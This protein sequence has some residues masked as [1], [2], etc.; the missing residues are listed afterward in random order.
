MWVTQ[1]QWVF[2]YLIC[3]LRWR[4]NRENEPK[5][6]GFFLF[7]FLFCFVFFSYE[8][9]LCFPCN[10]FGWEFMTLHICS[11][12][13]IY[14]CLSLYQRRRILKRIT[15]IMKQ[16]RRYDCVSTVS[17]QSMWSAG[18]VLFAWNSWRRWDCNELVIR[19]SET[20]MIVIQN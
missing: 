3:S 15:I 17:G 2:L 9:F 11:W 12:F 7:C 14:F 5:Q 18:S 20:R 8:V 6:E 10:Y 16:T 4:M 1:F 13:C 19:K